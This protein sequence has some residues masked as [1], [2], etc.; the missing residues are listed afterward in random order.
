MTKREMM[1][2]IITSPMYEGN[3]DIDY[4]IRTYSKA[5]IQDFFDEMI[6]SECNAW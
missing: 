6:E 3:C 2:V 1:E 5:E 4:M